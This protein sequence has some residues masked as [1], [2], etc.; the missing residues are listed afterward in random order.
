MLN[1]FGQKVNASISLTQVIKTTLNEIMNSLSPDVALLFIREGNE[2]TLQGFKSTKQ[3]FS[4]EKTPMHRAG[5]CLC[6]L[7]VSEGK[8][9]YALNIHNDPRCTWDECKKAGLHSFAALPLRF[10]DETIGVLGLASATERDFSERATFL[11]AMSHTIAIGIQNSLLFERVNRHSDELEERVRERTEALQHANL[12]L[13]ELDR[14]K[15]MF[16]ASI[17]HELR[18]P[19][20]SIIGFTGIILQELAGPINEE[21]EDQ[22]TRVYR[23]AQHLLNLISD[24]IDISKIEAGKVELTEEDFQ[25]REV[26]EEALSQVKNQI[27]TKKLAL[28]VTVPHDLP[29]HTDRKRLFQCIINYLS[30]AVKFTERGNIRIAARE[31]GDTLEITVKDTGIGIRQEDLPRLF[32]SFVRIDSPLTNSL[33]GTGLGLY[34]TKKIV[35]EVLG[36]KYFF[37]L[38]T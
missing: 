33:P 37:A 13:M 20:N 9:I 21:Q 38:N 31:V 34:L 36:G 1:A 11:E 15:S 14:L 24:V 28:E 23:A 3:Q 26:I 4:H 30:N 29:L 12:K 18:T 22:L 32:N 2:L 8:P 17:S 16:I 10:G 27:D 6:G 5:E 7:A 35:T 19:L 25:L